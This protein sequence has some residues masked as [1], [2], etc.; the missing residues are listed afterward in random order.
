ME[1]E[2]LH[3]VK[4][5][6]RK[7]FD[8]STEKDRQ[9][10]SIII[11]R[12]M[13]QGTSIFLERITTKYGATKTYRVRKYDADKD[14]LIV[15]VDEKGK[16]RTVS[17]RA[18]KAKTVA[19]APVAGGTNCGTLWTGSISTCPTC[20]QPEYDRDRVKELEGEMLMEAQKNNRFNPHF[21]DCGQDDGFPDIAEPLLDLDFLCHWPAPR[22]ITPHPFVSTPN[23]GPCSS[24][25]KKR[26]HKVH[27]WEIK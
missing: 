6:K 11:N 5:D 13:K 18:E 9:Q 24:C 7:N 15:A 3:N 8:T 14:L 12:L 22:K 10:L 17:T 20:E 27:M 1:L 26:S 16:T 21:L 25:N 4:G 2:I 19:V 23:N